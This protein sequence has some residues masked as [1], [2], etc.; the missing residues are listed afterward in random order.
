MSDSPPDPL[1][2][3]SG[4]ASVAAALKARRQRKQKSGRAADVKL[5]PIR[6]ARLTDVVHQDVS[7]DPSQRRAA[8]RQHLKQLD[9]LPSNSAF[10]RHRR[11][12]LRTALSLL[13][14]CLPLQ[15]SQCSPDCLTCYTA[16]ALKGQVLVL[17]SGQKCFQA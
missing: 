14:R 10:A 4:I 7:S 1:Q 3:A 11:Q 16:I 9:S 13:D 17:R 2:T 8:L 6:P 5:K 12:M 15:H